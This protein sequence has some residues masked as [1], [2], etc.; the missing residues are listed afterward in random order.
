[1]FHC[2]EPEKSKENRNKYNCKSPTIG[3]LFHIKEICGKCYD[4]EGK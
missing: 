2:D 4:L 1:M 3:D